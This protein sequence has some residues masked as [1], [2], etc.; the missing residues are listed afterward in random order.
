MGVDLEK[1]DLLNPLSEDS[2][3]SA[4]E[5][6]KFLGAIDTENKLT[7]H[8]KKMSLL[9]THPYWAHALLV[10]KKNNLLPT[11]SLI[12]ALLEGRPITSSNGLED[13]LPNAKPKIR[14]LLLAIGI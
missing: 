9:P 7:E 12:L 6:L 13:F 3:C 4:K 11:I 5:K 8:G 14:H 10:G 2:V 1:L